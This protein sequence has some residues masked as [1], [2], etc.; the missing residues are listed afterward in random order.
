M[1]PPKPIDYSP[2]VH[3]VLSWVGIALF[4]VLIVV[5]WTSDTSEVVLAWR[6]KLELTAA[7]FVLG[8]G[9]WAFARRSR[10]RA[11]AEA[12]EAELVRRHLGSR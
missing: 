2:T 4:V 3:R 8:G 5:A 1:K 6:L 11:E 7:A 12:R 10:L 9:L